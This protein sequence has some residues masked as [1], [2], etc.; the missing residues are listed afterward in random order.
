MPDYSVVASDEY[1]HER[2]Y[3]FMD[4]AKASVW[5]LAVLCIAMLGSLV[6]YAI[7][8]GRGWLVAG[9]IAGFFWLASVI[10][11]RF[12]RADYLAGQMDH[13]LRIIEAEVNATWN[14]S[15]RRSRAERGRDPILD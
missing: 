15:E 3:N 13:R 10:H 5:V 12:S 8:G 2:K 7:F 6:A 4:E 1:H 11:D 9:L 14:E